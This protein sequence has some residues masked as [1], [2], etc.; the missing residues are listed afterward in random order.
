MFEYF[1]PSLFSVIEGKTDSLWAKAAV[2]KNRKEL[3]RNY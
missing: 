1:N 3:R 2:T